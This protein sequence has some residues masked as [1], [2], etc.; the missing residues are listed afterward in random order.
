MPDILEQVSADA[1][2]AMRDRQREWE[3]RSS[4]GH[5]PATPEQI[6]AT[7]AYWEKVFSETPKRYEG[8]AVRSIAPEAMDYETAKRKV[9]EILQQ[10]AA[11]IEYLDNE[12]FR[13]QFDEQEKRILQNL[14]RYFINDPG[15]E[16]SLTKG[17]FLYGVPGTGKTEIMR[18]ISRFC[19]ENDLRKKFVFCSMSEIYTTAKSDSKYDSIT[20]N[21]QFDRV[22]D[23]FGR[24][25]G[26]VNQFGNLIDINETIVEQRY[27]RSRRYGQLTHF[28]ANGTP[29]EINE[30]FT[31]MVSDRLRSM[32]TGVYFKGKSKRK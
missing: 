16:W 31:P 28:I 8:P 11:Q 2:Q 13:W 26:Q 27:T 32:C 19:E 18:A 23:E 29:N 10:R 1:L 22:F 12:P 17:L 9:W 21:V 7:A 4:P 30:L 25:T 14:T 6:A 24:M 5:T 3:E 15:C 20:P